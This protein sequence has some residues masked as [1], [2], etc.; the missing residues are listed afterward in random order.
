MAFRDDAQLDTSQVEDRRG[1]GFGRVG[2]GGIAV[3]GGGLGLVVALVL[4]LVFGVNPFGGGSYDYPSPT[5]DVGGRAVQP[6]QYP[7]GNSSLATNCQSGADAN[8]RED[9]RVVGFVN[10]IQGYW[11]QEFAKRGGRY[12]PAKTVFF[13]DATQTACGTA[14]SDVGPF[15][16]PEDKHVYIDLGFYD[17]LHTRFGAKDGPLAQA[18]V[19]AH[20]YGH[21]VQDLTGTLSG[22]AN[23]GRGP[24]S[25]SVRTELQA[26]CYAGVWAGH[27]AETG[28]L[29][30]LSQQDVADALSAAA[31][32][33]DD[34]IQRQMSGRVNPEKFTHGS[35]Q[36]REHWFTVGYQTGDMGA[37]DTFR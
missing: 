19:L 27:A 2:G 15:Y 10:S 29:T 28:Y 24:S 32:V 22:G 5:G 4:A 6:G 8:N 17:E 20:E 16:C 7:A 31:A 25:G 9:C 11:S 34:H 36:Q 13:S 23:M 26:D 3:G 12:Q 1:G 33:G 30:P 14:T 35:S 21:H 37:C 18:Y